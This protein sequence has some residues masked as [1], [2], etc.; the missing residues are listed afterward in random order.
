MINCTKCG[1][2]KNTDCFRSRP[3]LKRGYH[4]WCKECEYK[5]NEIRRKLKHPP[6]PKII[7]E[8]NPDEVKLDAKKRMLKHRY[9]LDYNDYLLMYEQQG[10]KCKI[11]NVDKELGTVNGLLVDHCHITNKVRGLLCNNCNSGLGKFKD[12]YELLIKA[13]QYITDNS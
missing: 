11:C 6:K 1:E 2:C 12:N 10:G 13:S 4:S 3:K 9:R 8:V 5:A 7:K